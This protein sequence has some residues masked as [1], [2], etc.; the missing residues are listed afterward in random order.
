MIKEHQK[1]EYL[2][3][4]QDQ[5]LSK[6]KHEKFQIWLE[7]SSIFDTHNS[8]NNKTSLDLSNRWSIHD[9]ILCKL[10]DEE[11]IEENMKAWSDINKKFSLTLKWIAYLEDSKKLLRKAEIY[12]TDYPLIITNSIAFLALII[13]II[14]LFN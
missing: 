3:L 2:Q 1:I 4:I 7:V 9:F 11:Y 14:A 6:L 13:S 5:E 12:L 10:L 8:T